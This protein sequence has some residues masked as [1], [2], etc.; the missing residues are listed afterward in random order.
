MER[1]DK[2]NIKKKECE[3]CKKKFEYKY[4]QN[5]IPRRF[6][7]QECNYEHKRKERVEIF[8]R[9]KKLNGGF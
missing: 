7:C 9:I 6:C 8:E 3:N 5:S 2:M 1:L 4:I